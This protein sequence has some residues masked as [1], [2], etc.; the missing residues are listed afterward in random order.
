MHISFWLNFI[1]VN[2]LFVINISASNAYENML[3][4]WNVKMYSIEV[5]CVTLLILF[6]QKTNAVETPVE[7]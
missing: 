7:L 1:H 4:C 6:N 2:V 3:K 5:L